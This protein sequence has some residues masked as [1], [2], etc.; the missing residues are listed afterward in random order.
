M[1]SE[2]T[3]I[4]IGGKNRGC[5][6][7][8]RTRTT[9]SIASRKKNFRTYLLAVIEQITS[10]LG[11]LSEQ[12]LVDVVLHEF[13]TSFLPQAAGLTMEAWL[14]K[15]RNQIDQHLNIRP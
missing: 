1:L 5:G 11:T 12:E 2:R 4:K 7:S 13:H 3:S 8:P 15:V 10:V 9:L 6:T 14:A